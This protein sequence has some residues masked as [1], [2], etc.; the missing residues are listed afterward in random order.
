MKKVILAAVSCMIL[1]KVASAQPRDAGQAVV[2]RGWEAE[3]SVRFGIYD[4][5]ASTE[6][7]SSARVQAEP[8]ADSLQGMWEEA[9][10]AT[11]PA[12]APY[13]GLRRGYMHKSRSPSRLETGGFCSE[14]AGKAP[15]EN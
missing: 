3:D 2:P 9:Y 13:T 5:K 15:Q 14:L 11:I 12:N 4:I 10:G 8:L 1:I 7:S 6:Y